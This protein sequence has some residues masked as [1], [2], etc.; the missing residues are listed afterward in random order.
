MSEWQFLC[1][2]SS[3]REGP[4]V[5]K[6]IGTVTVGAFLVEGRCR[7]IEDICPHAL[8]YLS[9]GYQE[10]GIIECPLHQARFNLLTGECL[11]GPIVTMNV[12]TFESKVEGDQVFVKLPGS[13]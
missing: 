7:A 13:D 12:R 9:D 5:S 6:Q 2:L 11:D 10:A 1:E 8:A 4:P 3:L